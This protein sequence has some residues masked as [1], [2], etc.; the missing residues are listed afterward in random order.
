METCFSVDS[1]ALAAAPIS[2]HHPESS[3]HSQQLPVE[4]LSAFC[5]MHVPELAPFLRKRFLVR[6]APRVLPVT[7]CLFLEENYL[8]VSILPEIVTILVLP[9]LVDLVGMKSQPPTCTVCIQL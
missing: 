6:T 2:P 5:F 7:Y 8:V 9:A 3:Q 4:L 1:K